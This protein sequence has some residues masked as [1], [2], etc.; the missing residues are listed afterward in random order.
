VPAVRSPVR[1]FS[2]AHAGLHDGQFEPLHGHTFA[3]T[4]RLHCEPGNAGM[5]AGFRMFREALAVPDG[6]CRACERDVFELASAAPPGH[7][8]LASHA[9]AAACWRSRRHH[10]V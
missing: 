2:A 4:V 10:D 6:A 9:H 8:G 5:L 1:V 3:V 7:P